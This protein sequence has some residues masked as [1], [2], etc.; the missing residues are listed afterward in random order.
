MSVRDAIKCSSMLSVA[1]SLANYI[2][3]WMGDQVAPFPSHFDSRFAGAECVYSDD[4]M[5][6]LIRQHDIMRDKDYYR[7]DVYLGEAE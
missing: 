1:N 2:Q 3:A 7:M 6:R 5:V 4:R